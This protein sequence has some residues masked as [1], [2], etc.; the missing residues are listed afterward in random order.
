MEIALKNIY[1]YEHAAV[2]HGHVRVI[3]VL[4]VSPAPTLSVVYCCGSLDWY[5]GIGLVETQRG[6]LG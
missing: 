1:I 3:F 2:V 6:P 4:E 5:V